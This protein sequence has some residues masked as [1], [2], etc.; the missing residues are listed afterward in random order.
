MSRQE[1]RAHARQ[2]Q[3]GAAPTANFIEL[4]AGAVAVAV[5]RAMAEVQLQ[6]GCAVCVHD[7]KVREQIALK[8]LEPFE[9][10]IRQAVTVTGRG[11]VCWEHAE[12]APRF[13]TLNEQRARAGAPPA[14]G[15]DLT[16]EQFLDRTRALAAAEL[17]AEKTG[18]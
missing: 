7:A 3:H 17:A 5:Q 10:R 4:V 16:A 6:P 13:L 15:P 11:P 9:P 12:D 18:P 14:A 8:A 2:A 1:A